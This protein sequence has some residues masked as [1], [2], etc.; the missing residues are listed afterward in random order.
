VER[1]TSDGRIALGAAGVHRAP[2]PGVASVSRLW[3]G[4]GRARGGSDG[5]AR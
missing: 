4:V 3:G 5:M 1:V 2:K